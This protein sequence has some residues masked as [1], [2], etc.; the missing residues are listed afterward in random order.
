[1]TTTI[2]QATTQQQS[3]ALA[4]IEQHRQDLSLVLPS[5]ITAET[6]VRVA[7]GAVR[8]SNDLWKA[9]NETPGSMMSA[10]MEAAQLGLNPGTE[11][12]YLTP[13]RVK[14]NG[15]YRWEVVG[16]TGYVGEIELIYRAGAVA[17]VF[18]EL[19]C[20]GD[21]F[22]WRPGA[23][24][25]HIPPRWHG[26]MKR[27]Y[28]EVPDDD[29]FG[30]RDGP[31][32]VK[33]S[34]CYCEMKDDGAISKVAIAGQSRIRRAMQASGTA[35]ASHSPWKSDY[36]A[37]VLKTA[38]HI[39]AN[40]VPT[41]AEYQRE[42]HRAEREVIAA[43]GVPPAQFL[44]SSPPPRP[45]GSSYVE[46]EVVPPTPI[47]AP[48]PPPD[49]APARPS[50]R[51]DSQQPNG[52][53]ESSTAPAGRTERNK[54]FALLRDGSVSSTD[55]ALRL[56]IVSRILNRP[57]AEPVTSF[58]QLSAAE[59]DTVNEFL[60]RRKDAGDLTHTLVDLG[61]AAAETTEPP[62]EQAPADATEG[63][64]P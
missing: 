22:I 51:T 5:H 3:G 49:P 45:A 28:H 18:C 35:E 16:I 56:R 64:Q 15:E 2:K 31:D 36:G 8:K 37:M 59:V 62:A 19:V 21:T 47:P 50:R 25:N 4:V 20:Q 53:G 17:T 14:R 10:L 24:D 26:P 41:S 23:Y 52:D 58:D 6:W 40:F 44:P 61:A 1:M 38:V 60:Q 13:R 63:E 55:R 57:P 29:W 54:L 12:Y 46:G 43:T 48:A 7:M 9:C 11:E 39:E 30:D 42:R 34:Y 27:P 32:R 33:G